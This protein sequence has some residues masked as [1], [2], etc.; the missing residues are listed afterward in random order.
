[1]EDKSFFNLA[2]AIPMLASMEQT[3]G[4]FR[5][6]LKQWGGMNTLRILFK[7]G[8]KTGHLKT[9]KYLL[10]F[11]LERL[12]PNFLISMW[13]VFEDFECLFYISEHVR[14]AAKERVS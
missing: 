7:T 1:M 4:L 6:F 11:R 3:R 2:K 14:Y 10:N 12:T 13:E 8:K 9:L 5:T